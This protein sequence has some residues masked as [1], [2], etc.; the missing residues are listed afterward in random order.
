[1][2]TIRQNQNS[3]ASTSFAESFSAWEVIGRGWQ[4]VDFETGIEPAFSRF[5]PPQR[6][7]R[8]VDDGRVPSFF[9]RLFS[10]TG[11]PDQI[12]TNA[13]LPADKPIQIQPPSVA[14]SLT[15]FQI[16]LPGELSVSFGQTEQLL[17]NLASSASFI[18]FEI[19][20]TSREIALQITCPVAQ[21]TNVFAQLKTH[22]PA[23]D[24]READDL[25]EQNL[26]LSQA[27]E[28]LTI[29]FGLGRDWFIPLP[30]GKSSATDTLLPL[31]ASMEEIKDG[32]TICLQALLCRTRG[33][34]Q[35]A[36]A[37]AIFDRNGKPVFANLQNYHSAIKEKL[38][39]SLFAV[40][41][42]LAVQSDSKEKSLQAARRTSA[43]FKQFST[44]NGN[45][46]IP[47]RNDNLESDKHL[48]S[49]LT[50]TSFRTGMLL[51]ACE[52]S[53]IVH[54][55]GDTVKSE[56][57]KRNENRTK[58]APDFATQGNLILGENHHLG[59]K[60]V[61]KLSDEQ[62]LKHLWLLGAS[63][64][65]KTTAILR[66]VEQDLQSG[67][68]VCVIDPHD[69]ISDVIARIPDHRI[70]D[71][72]LFDPAD[73]E[74]PVGFNILSA[75]SEL[76][77]NLLASD[78]VSIF[79]K[80][81]TSWGDV[82]STL[83][84]NAIL[85]FLLSTKGGTLV[86]L[87]HF[88]V[89]KDFR[90]E[91]LKT[92]GDEEIKFYWQ[93][94]FPAMGGKPHAPLL[95]RLDL[96]LRSQLI[97]HIVA[98]KD[99]KLDFRRIMDERKILLV[100]LTH[101]SIGGQ[102]S[103]L[104]ASLV[105]AKLYQA[106]LSRQNAAA[107]NRPPFFVYLDEA[108]HYFHIPSV[109]LLLSEGRKFGISL[110]ASMQDIQQITSRDA[111]ILSSLMTN[112]HTRLCFR[113]DTDA[114][115]LAKGFSFF[116]AEHLKNL[117]VGECIVRF[118]QSR[119]DFNLKT[120]PLEPVLPE[121]AGKRR[122]AIIEYSRQTYGTPKAEVEAESSQIISNTIISKQSKPDVVPQRKVAEISAG[123]PPKTELN[124]LD[125]PVKAN[126]GRGGEHH[127]ELQ[128]VIKRM[129][130]GNGFSATI[131]KSVADGHIDVSLENETFKI[132]AEVSVTSSADYEVKNI[133]KC[134][135]AGYDYAVVVA[136]NH[137]KIPLL[138]ERVQTEFA[139]GEQE[140]VK[141]T[142][143]TG[144]LEFLRQLTKPETKKV[145]KKG[146][147]DRLN[148]TE[149][150][151]FL[152]VSTSTLY[153]WAREGKIPFFRVGREYQFDRTELALIGRHDLSGKR[154]AVVNLPPV[155]I[156]KRTPKTKKEQNKRYRKML[157]LE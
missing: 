60:R 8:S 122:N 116:T 91:F 120:F 97:R 131:E 40:V 58:S 74:Y 85:A 61:I 114:E 14:A 123:N 42:R 102:I 45:E 125:I 54:L 19:I 10:N 18:S 77:R 108:H 23:V 16:Y 109:A 52:L 25:L 140:K 148:I 66:C 75:H 71:V 126:Q 157:N 150:S 11:R 88:L 113:S 27:N 36:A 124:I 121:V 64:S 4:V 143:L 38:A 68:G 117:G 39:S 134:L 101:G 135:N 50:R 115:K 17:L 103:N 104:F 142:S 81:S 13:D 106:A 9:T 76:E 43:F 56:K 22:L 110:L 149:A 46:L 1:M 59:Q 89:D 20:G 153:R 83:L 26:H 79:Q 129:A 3:P 130:E 141:V 155:E 119:F 145:V 144:L 15:S 95:M 107:S 72:I 128:T 29:D 34:W 84:H 12:S 139:P 78:L 62:R 147:G 82:I 133:R 63:G 31:V 32:E 51:S 28:S 132:A 111:D 70:K 96:F 127:R 47:L 100:K 99:N 137:E 30:S 138:K 5:V 118:E 156:K 65:G 90:N 94:E 48:R 55:P 21:K 152:N 98:Q 146:Q 53:A 33:N 151:K 80:F 44:P 67:N 112:C 105:I 7:N 49:F 37:V 73:S 2:P 87:K 41:V 93:K 92:V 136:S 86:D 6:I 57:L 24:V 69:L 35:Q 154:K